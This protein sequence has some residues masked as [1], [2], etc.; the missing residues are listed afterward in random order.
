M[1]IVY[2]VKDATSIKSNSDEVKTF[3]L[4]RFW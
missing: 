3:D 4:H 1:C 2:E